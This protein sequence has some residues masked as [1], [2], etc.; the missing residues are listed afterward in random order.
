MK[1]YFVA[2]L[3]LM[4]LSCDE[5]PEQQ[6]NRLKEEIK[7]LEIRND[8]MAD[9]IRK[10]NNWSVVHRKM[11][12]DNNKAKKE[13]AILSEKQKYWI[14]IYYK[15][16]GNRNTPGYPGYKAKLQKEIYKK[17]IN[18]VIY[19]PKPWHDKVDLIWKKIQDNPE[20]INNKRIIKIKLKKF[21]E[22]E[23]K[24]HE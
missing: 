4:A 17:K 3:A 13:L 1:H 18:R 7:T 8:F 23:A 9:S 2:F 14:D 5:T 21:I 10:A 6:M 11:I 24:S 16:Y 15:N 19:R 22:L 20:R 12:E